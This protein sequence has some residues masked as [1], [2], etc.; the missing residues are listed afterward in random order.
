MY[1]IN[2]D[3]RWFKWEEM[4]DHSPA[5]RYRRKMIIELISTLKCRNILD[6]GCGNGRLMDEMHKKLKVPV[7]GIDLSKSIIEK[8]K[9]FYPNYEFYC[10]DI[11]KEYLNRKFELVVCSEILEHLEEIDQAITNL[12]QMVSRYFIITVPKGRIFPIDRKMGH[13]RH[14]S[15]ETIHRLLKK[16]GFFVVEYIEWGFPFHT[17]YK[18]LINIFPNYFNLA[19]AECKYNFYKRLLSE[20][21]SFAFATNSK[22]MGFQIIAL[23]ERKVM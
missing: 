3:A 14:F 19:F 15:K 4:I 21:L 13:K 22:K 18:Y 9:K 8:N 23:A 6:V 16:N 11:Q 20:L 1:E 7:C 10:L 5:P 17:L 2:Y 12:S